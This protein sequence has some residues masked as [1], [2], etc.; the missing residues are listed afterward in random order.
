MLTSLL[1]MSNSLQDSSHFSRFY[2]LLLIFN[3]A[4]LF[5]LVILIAINLRRLIR[6]LR[7]RV[8]GSRMTLRMVAMF[9]ILSVTPVLVVYY[10][11]LD[12]L[13][14]GIDN[15]FDLRVEQ[16]LDD[17]L[18]LSRQS[19][20]A[21]MRELLKKTRQIAGDFSDITEV[22]LPFEIDDLRV[23]NG[24][25]ELTL[26]T[27]QG[28]IIASSADDPTHLVPDRPSDTILLQLQQGNS[29]T[30]L[31]TIRDSGLHIRVVVNVPGFGI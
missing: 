18:E 3:A 29:Y 22:A 9:S 10:F 20:D 31:D 14:R 1:M 19:L 21:R 16:A 15:W 8:P 30:G 24:A 25:K 27:R 23:R 5:A 17:S 7:R 28:S 11:S 12:F 4:G 6:Q 2:L 13:L 26:M